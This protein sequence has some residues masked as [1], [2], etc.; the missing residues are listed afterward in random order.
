MMHCKKIGYFNPHWLCQL[1]ASILASLSI[2]NVCYLLYIPND[3][4]INKLIA[5]FQTT[6]KV[7]VQVYFWHTLVNDLQQ[8]E[9][10]LR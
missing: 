1:H 4:H 5:S 9:V 8:S 2:G 6:S 10:Q 3:K 7:H